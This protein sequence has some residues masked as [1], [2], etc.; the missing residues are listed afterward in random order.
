[1]HSRRVRPRPTPARMHARPPLA[2]LAPP[3]KRA[4]RPHAAHDGR[5]PTR[6][7]TRA[8]TCA[9][10]PAGGLRFPLGLPGMVFYFP[11]TGRNASSWPWVRVGSPLGLFTAPSQSGQTLQ[12]PPGCSA[13]SPAVR[14]ETSGGRGPVSRGPPAGLSAPRASAHRRAVPAGCPGPCPH[15]PLPAR[16]FNSLQ[17]PDAATC[18]SRP[19]TCRAQAGTGDDGREA[20]CGTAPS[21]PLR[22]PSPFRVLVSSK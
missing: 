21:P 12:S 9:P 4:A 2:A 19:P 1:M 8:G 17:P 14:S 22:S 10:D 18:I 7:R 15:P 6:A 16:L 20:G 11:L 13:A 3:G 5:P